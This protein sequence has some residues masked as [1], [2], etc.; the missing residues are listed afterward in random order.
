M[1]QVFPGEWNDPRLIFNFKP[2]TPGWYVVAFWRKMIRRKIIWVCSPSPALT[3]CCISQTCTPA[4]MC[5]ETL[6][7]AICALWSG[8]RLPRSRWAPDLLPH[9]PPP[10]NPGWPSAGATAGYRACLVVRGSCVS[11]F[12]MTYPRLKIRV[13]PSVAHP[14]PAG[15]C[16][17]CSPLLHWCRCRKCFQ[18]LRWPQPRWSVCSGC[19]D[20]SLCWS[21]PSP[22]WLPSEDDSRQWS[23]G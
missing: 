18:C 4:W 6:A 2:A 5:W 13:N 12:L 7:C 21:E 19:P 3:C 11:V 16:W 20:G 10:I 17:N 8:G 1:T 23:H 15:K 14:Q 22:L 9:S